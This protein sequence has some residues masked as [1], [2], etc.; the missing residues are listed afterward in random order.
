VVDKPQRTLRYTER[1]KINLC[2]PLS[3]LW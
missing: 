1:R 3:S 2:A